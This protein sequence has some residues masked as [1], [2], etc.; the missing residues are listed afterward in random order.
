M[1]QTINTKNVDR[2]TKACFEVVMQNMTVEQFTAKA[3]EYSKLA[4]VLGDAK[5]EHLYI[6]AR[7]ALSILIDTNELESIRKIENEAYPKALLKYLGE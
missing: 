6:K 1:S 4:E 7:A 3:F 5:K 2:A